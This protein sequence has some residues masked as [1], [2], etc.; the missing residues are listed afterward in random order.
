METD[1]I[2]HQVLLHSPVEPYS[3]WLDTT[4]GYQYTSRIRD[5]FVTA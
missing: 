1:T 3:D 5:R 4:A 2:A